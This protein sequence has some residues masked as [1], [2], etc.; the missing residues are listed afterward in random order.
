M[1]VIAVANQ[2]GGVGKTT[3]VIELCTIFSKKGYKVLGIDMDGQRNFSMYSGADLSNP[4]T[5]YR[6]LDAE[7]DVSDS[8]QHLKNYDII[9]SDSK[10]SLAQKHFIDGDDQYLLS[11]AL[12]FLKDGGNDYDYVFIDCPPQ[13]GILQE[14]AIVAADY[15]IGITIVDEGA[16][17]GLLELA[18]DVEL[19]AKRKSSHAKFLGL[20]YN[21]YRNTNEDINSVASMEEI[22]EKI[23]TTAFETIIRHSIKTASCKKRR[24]SISELDAKNNVSQDFAE[25]ANEIEERIKNY[26]CQG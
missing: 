4:N 23:G 24:T 10:L 21:D 25:L 26:E 9:I 19:K 6:A 16:L 3:T 22:A 2:K 17:M 12:G 14:M 11:D 20:L 15:I 1:H 5:I 18:A 8:I 13:R 7:C